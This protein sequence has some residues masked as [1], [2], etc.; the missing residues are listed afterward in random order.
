M[1]VLVVAGCSSNRNARISAS[2]QQNL[3]AK[4]SPSAESV[5]AAVDRFYKARQYAPVWVQDGDLSKVTS[6]LGVLRS[7]EA[8]GLVASDYGEEAIAGAIASEDRLDKS[9][10]RLAQLD[11]D[12]TTNLLA[13]GHDVALGRVN[14]REI[15]PHW[16]KQRTPPDFVALL[17]QAAAGDLNTWL[18]SV[19]PKH[20][21]YG[22]LQQELTAIRAQGASP[23]DERSRLL[24]LNLERWRWLPDDLGPRH[25]LVN[26]PSFHLVVRESGRT[27]LDMKVVVGKAEATRRTPI[28]SS[29]MGTVVFSPYWNVPDSIVEGETAPAVVRDPSFLD[30]N[31]IEILRRSQRGAELVEPASVDWDD[32]EELKQLLFRQRPG[33][34]NALGHVKFLFPNPFH[35]YLHDTPAD[36]LFARSGRALSHGCVRL[37]QPE[38]LAQYLLRDSAE[39]N[40]E[41]IHTAMDS[42]DET[43][44]A[45]K[46]KI[47]V[48]I[49]YFTAWPRTGGGFETWPDVYGHDAKQRQN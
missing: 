29:E 38:A 40:A 33:P 1:A 28:F 35:V 37:E 22:A 2:I 15:D 12:V 18:S 42:G 48:H 11:V 6:A 30:R 46:E 10:E 5:P 34:G 3:T 26:V 47:P 49:V 27:A 8:H 39:W 44:V 45:L 4:P 43:A 19:Q 36:A 17:A 14:L 25:I 20:S 32:A 23:T 21:E 7:A 41:R 16:K 9:T 31:N 24:A 13:L